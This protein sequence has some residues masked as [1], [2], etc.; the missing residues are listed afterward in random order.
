MILVFNYDYFQ[1]KAREKTII[2]LV[3]LKLAFIKI[4]RFINRNF[5]IIKHMF[6]LNY[7]TRTLVYHL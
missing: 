2:C 3:K 1:Y 6:E 7:F 4:E 5:K